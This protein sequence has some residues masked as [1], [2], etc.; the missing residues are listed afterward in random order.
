MIK[1]MLNYINSINELPCISED[2]LNFV[3]QHNGLAGAG[4]LEVIKNCV[5]YMD[6]DKCYLEVGIYQGVNFVG[7]ARS[8]NKF[9]YGVDNFSQSFLENQMYPNLTTRQVVE[10]KIND[11][12]LNNAFL[13]EQDFREFLKNT[14]KLDNKKVEVYFYDGPHEYQDQIDGVEMAFDLLSD[15]A[16]IFVDDYVS[17]IVQ[18]SIKTLLNK[19][20]ELSLLKIFVGPYNTREYFN[21]GQ[22]ALL[23][24]KKL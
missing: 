21:Q 7:V 12:K 6:N 8:T 19:H 1:L 14:K 13:I 16:I 18:K 3:L 11:N 22:V 2:S 9:C 20:K 15:E 23:Y 4:T 24:R 17:E 5:K 10:K